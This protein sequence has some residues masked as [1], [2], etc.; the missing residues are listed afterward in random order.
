MGRR[1]DWGGV[2]F[3]KS[4]EHHKMLAAAFFLA[5]L[6]ALGAFTAPSPSG[7]LCSSYGGVSGI[8]CYEAVSIA[9]AKYHGTV[10]TILPRDSFDTVDEIT[11]VWLV[12]I[13]L[14]KPMNLGGINSDAIV[15]GIDRISGN[16]LFL[17]RGVV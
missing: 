6:A 7:D 11:D 13:V 10:K 9:A 17:T 2:F 16:I 8:S 4:P 1:V 12:N 15:A 14:E 3:K 5:T